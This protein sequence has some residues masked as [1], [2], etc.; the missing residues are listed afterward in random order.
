MIGRSDLLAYSQLLRKRR[1]A[2]D[3]AA[4]KRILLELAKRPPDK[5][6]AIQD[7]A[8]K[9]LTQEPIREW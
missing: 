1:E 8:I 5:N 4:F 9:L 6:A 3:R 2:K 7:L